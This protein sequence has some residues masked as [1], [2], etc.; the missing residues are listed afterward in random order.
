MFGDFRSIAEPTESS[1]VAIAPSLN[2][3]HLKV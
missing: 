1:L 3:C 2:T